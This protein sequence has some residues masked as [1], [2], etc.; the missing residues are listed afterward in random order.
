MQDFIKVPRLDFKITQ[1]MVERFAI[2]TGDRSSLHLDPDFGRKTVFRSNIVHG[3]LSFS[4]ISALQLP[5]EGFFRRMNA[6]FARPVFAGDFLQL[7]AL[8]TDAANST[9][10][11]FSLRKTDGTV[12]ANGSLETFRSPKVDTAQPRMLSDLEVIPIEALEEQNLEPA[13]INKGD[14]NA[15]AFAISPHQAAA[16]DGIL[17]SG[18]AQNSAGRT[19][20]DESMRNLLGAFM[21]SPF[22]GMCIPGR[23]GLLTSF[24]IAYN[25]PLVE[26][27]RYEF[28]GT[29][30]FK[31]LSTCTIV[32]TFSIQESSTSH[33]IAFGKITSKINEVEDT[34]PL[35]TANASL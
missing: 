24:E 35:S 26:G 16:L 14:D 7:E 31:S 10:A 1:D 25:Q 33:E 32:E 20:S 4:F 13:D 18:L 12:V 19:C 29:V 8:S 27:V 17:R 3:M 23:L 21:I 6:R 30:L 34:V 22:V 2:L 28:R 5:S 11:E 15:I 9:L